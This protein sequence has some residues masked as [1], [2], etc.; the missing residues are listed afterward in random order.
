MSSHPADETRF[1]ERFLR[2]RGQG[3]RVSVDQVLTE[4]GMAGDPATRA[5][6][7]AELSR[8]LRKDAAG[9]KADTSLAEVP[10]NQGPLPEIPGYD[11]IEEVGRGGMGVVY[12]AY[13]QSTGRRVAI[14]FISEHVAARES[15]RRRFEREVELVARLQHPFIVSVV[16]SGTHAGHR[17]SVQEF[18]DGVT[19]DAF[20]A[21]DKE[22][23]SGKSTRLDVILNLLAEVCDA[24]EYAHQRG[25]LHRDLKPSNILVDDRGH[26]HIVDFGLAK[27]IDPLASKWR[28]QTVGEPGE[29]LGTLGYMAPE[30]ARGAHDQISIRNDIYSLGA[31]G[32]EALTGRLPCPTEGTLQEVLKRIEQDDPPRPSSLNRSITADLDAVLLRALEKE[33]QR[34]YASAGEMR[35]DL[36]RVIT[37]EPV[38][39]RPVGRIVRTLR[40]A[41][42]RP[43]QAALVVALLLLVSGLAAAA[44]L[45]STR[46]AATARAVEEDL[47]E[48]ARFQQQSSWPEA[49]GALERAKVRIGDRGYANLRRRLDEAGKNLALVTRL[50]AIRM[51]RANLVGA[52]QS[53]A[54]E[55]DKDYQHAFVQAGFTFDQA[56]EQ[57]AQW[58]R[59]SDVRGPI[60][61]ALMDWASLT[62]DATRKGW[63]QQVAQRVDPDAWRERMQDPE[64]WEDPASLA[65]WARTVPVETLP[66]QTLVALGERLYARN[67]DAAPFLRRVQRVHPDDFWAN[68]YLGS[69][70]A[71]NPSEA[72]AYY[73]AALA[74]RPNASMVHNNLAMLLSDTG[75]QDEAFD[76]FEAAARLTDYPSAH[77][78]LANALRRKGDSAKACQ[79][80]E[81]ALQGGISTFALHNNYGMALKEGG[82]LDEAITQYEQALRLDRK[83]PA[84]HVNLA[85]ALAEMGELDDAIGHVREAARLAPK[86][87]SILGRL[88]PLLL[89]QR[90][91][92]E[93]RA[94]WKRTLDLD[95]PD[96]ETWS[97]YAELCLFLGQEAE[98]R[99]ARK[100]LLARFASAADPF[101]AE[102]TGRACLLLP[103]SGDDLLKAAALCDRAL[104]GTSP[105]AV[106]SRPYFM[107][108]K[109]LAEYRQDNYDR[110][111][112]IMKGEASGVLGPAPK[113]VLAMAQQRKGL[114][115][116]AAET[117]AAA[118]AQFDWG[119]T[120]AIDDSTVWIYH[121]LRREAEAQIPH[122]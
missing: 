93:A 78:N 23:L 26:P 51:E 86:D 108:A 61:N 46:Q 58:V 32:Y 118:I 31:I 5:I 98:Y 50:D 74:L 53:V 112:T 33:P 96:H 119:E 7:I 114:H 92:E 72:I 68:F 100:A 29:V 84:G 89:R 37:R 21:R 75:H 40:W 99:L 12:E 27:D 18:V 47:R 115:A 85:D 117:L 67:V 116:E 13:Q 113:L 71:S 94:A 105:A 64:A 69:A 80:Y 6:V 4:T 54:P 49:A 44:V 45:F 25:V 15:V 76:H 90:K 11:L 82:R 14:K 102:R 121:V 3:Q 10:R 56:P 38:R 59:A 55:I 48:I 88:H 107:F 36:R 20:L 57:A 2:Q 42:R 28:D 39:A 97:G 8:R 66:V 62:A 77:L 30:Q 103:D 65:E 104:A 17:H 22:R 19:L 106:N 120:Q 95:P 16:D 1:V 52:Q 43:S 101:I 73:R 41:Q 70:L 87:W 63:L 9:S 109:G 34:R 24:V 91:R 60:G 83:I 111:L 81:R 122:N 110:A 35:D 79:H